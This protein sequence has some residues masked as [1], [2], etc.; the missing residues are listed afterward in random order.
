MKSLF[1]F[2]L[3]L[4]SHF[5][6]AQ[7]DGIASQVSTTASDTVFKA[8]YPEGVYETKED[9]V[10]KRNKNYP[11]TAKSIE[12]RNKKKVIYKPETGVPQSCLFYYTKN[13]EM[14]R[15]VFAISYG[16]EI[17]FQLNAIMEYANR[18]DRFQN[19]IHDYPFVQVL[20]SGGHYMYTEA[21]LADEWEQG[22]AM[23]AG[24]G[25]YDMAVRMQLQKGVVWDLYKFEFN[26]F[27]NCKDFNAFIAPLYPEGVQQCTG[28]GANLADVRR[29]IKAI[30]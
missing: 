27:K 14:V 6:S 23:N 12:Y 17:Y 28:K 5:V 11:L 13:D 16:G 21:P 30:R 18:K 24:P 8:Y 4:L 20:F 3:L 29:A 26:V 22:L 9:F 25:G 7:T 19:N 1:F 10:R 15:D 2:A